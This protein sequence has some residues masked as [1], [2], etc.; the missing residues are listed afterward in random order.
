MLGKVRKSDHRS[1][2][3]TIGPKIGPFIGPKIGPFIGSKIGPFIG[4]K[5]GPLVHENIPN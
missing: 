3:R 2:N 4:P 5:I 1:K